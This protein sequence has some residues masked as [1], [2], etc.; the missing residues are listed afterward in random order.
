MDS[1]CRARPEAIGQGDKIASRIDVLQL[2]LAGA[3]LVLVTIAGYVDLRG[4][5][6]AAE[7]T[8]MP[9][10]T[11]AVV[12]AVGAIADRI[13]VFRILA[14]AVLSDK[15]PSLIAAMSVLAF[16]AIVSGAL[17]LDVAAVVAAPLAVRVAALKGLNPGRL[18]ISTALAANATSFLLPSSNLTNLLL[19][20]RSSTLVI[21]YVREGWVAWLLV[22]VLTVVWLA[23][24]NRPSRRP[25]PVVSSLA[26]TP[27][28][29]VP[30]VLDLLLMFVIASS[31][32]ALLGGGLTLHGGF[33]AQFVVGSL[34]AAGANNLPAAVAVQTT[35]HSVP[36][37]AILSMAMGPNLLVTGSVASIIC[38]RI[39]LSHG[40][41][42]GSVAFS[43]LGTVMLPI[44]FLA[45][46][47]GL[48]L[49]RLG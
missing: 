27:R 48:H 35:G 46:C 26:T 32:R 30:T 25:S 6:S 36:W 18:V 28:S 21:E 34:I 38:R 42:F 15:L 20:D 2:I 17:N 5:G 8:A 9:F 4:L 10:L 7:R 41:R 11:L 12:I 40:V 3:G 14:K 47:A 45:A 22:T 31:I 39:G 37:A 16:T 24:L 44:Q 43:L 23:L 13:G 29:L 19:L 49:V 1:R 33:V